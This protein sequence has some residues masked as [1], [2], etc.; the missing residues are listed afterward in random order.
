M[1]KNGFKSDII[2]LNVGGTH[3][4]MVSQ[5]VLTSVGGS[6]LAKMFSGMHSLKKVDNSVFL[7]RDGLTFQ[8]LVNY[9]RNDR[10]VYPEFEN[11]NE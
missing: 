7:D 6:N 5:K 8:T 4:V 11:S 2:N 10:K 1:A 3:K 9:L